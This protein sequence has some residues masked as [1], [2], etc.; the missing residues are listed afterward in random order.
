MLHYR[1][2]QQELRAKYRSDADYQPAPLC[3][4]GSAHA[5]LTSDRRKVDC[6]ACLQQLQS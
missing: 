1:V 4:N 6:P 3:S 2:T 5:V